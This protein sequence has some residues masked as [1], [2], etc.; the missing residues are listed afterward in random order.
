M[1]FI[2]LDSL[3]AIDAERIAVV[4]YFED[5]PVAALLEEA[6]QALDDEYERVTTSYSVARQDRVC[7]TVSET[8]RLSTSHR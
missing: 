7:G 4:D 3:E 5:Y 1:A 8:A 6:A 2:P